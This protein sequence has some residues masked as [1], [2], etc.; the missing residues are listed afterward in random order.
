MKSL[1]T[2]LGSWINHLW[3]IKL[4]N[5]CRNVWVICLNVNYQECTIK[6]KKLT[7]ASYFTGIKD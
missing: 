1:T 2:K 3:T 4:R 7:H 6:R 5:I